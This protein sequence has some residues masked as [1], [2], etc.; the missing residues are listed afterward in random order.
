M[1]VAGDMRQMSFF[2][3]A[4]RDVLAER[5]RNMPLAVKVGVDTDFGIDPL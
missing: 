4:G 1:G 3:A 5:F 2:G